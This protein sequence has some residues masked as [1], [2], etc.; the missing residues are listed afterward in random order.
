MSKT[1]FDGVGFNGKDSRGIR[2]NNN[3]VIFFYVQIRRSCDFN[4]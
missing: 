3:T 2:I 4:R 1:W